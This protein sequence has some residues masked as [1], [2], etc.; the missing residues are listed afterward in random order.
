M[1]LFILVSHIATFVIENIHHK[2]LIPLL[3]KTLYEYILECHKL[4]FISIIFTI[5]LNN[6]Q[7]SLRLDIGLDPNC[8]IPS[9]QLLHFWLLQAYTSPFEFVLIEASSL[10]S[11]KTQQEPFESYFRDNCSSV[12]FKNI[13]GDAVL[14]VPCPAVG[15][16]LLPFNHLANF[17]RKGPEEKACNLIFI[18]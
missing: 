6:K 17:V 5:I 7:N 11:I 4:C 12:A 9:V 15:D 1:K 8:Y 14:V 18:F 3:L 10:E 13:A 2:Q 16:D